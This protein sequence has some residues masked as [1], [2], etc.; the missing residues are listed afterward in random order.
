LL[1]LLIKLS[2]VILFYKIIEK[3]VRFVISDS[4]KMRGDWSFWFC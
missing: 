4:V 3:K 2:G 1:D